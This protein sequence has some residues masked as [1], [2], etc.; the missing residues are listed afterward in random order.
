ME[1]TGILSLIRKR[2]FYSYSQNLC[3]AEISSY[4]VI[5]M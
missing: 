3:A 2:F 4:T 1:L 5:V